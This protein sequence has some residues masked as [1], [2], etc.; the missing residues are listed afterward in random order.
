VDHGAQ[1]LAYNQIGIIDNIEQFV[2]HGDF[3]FITLIKDA[4][5]KPLRP[6]LVLDPDGNQD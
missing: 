2:G 3:A 4:K 1:I 6:L 5:N